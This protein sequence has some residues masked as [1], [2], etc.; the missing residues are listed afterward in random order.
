MIQLGKYH[1]IFLSR[2]Y[3]YGI[4]GYVLVFI[5]GGGPTYKEAEFI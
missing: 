5:L 3:K 1:L 2:I 4:L